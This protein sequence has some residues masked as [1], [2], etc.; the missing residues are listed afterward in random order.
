M[1]KFSDKYINNF[2]ILNNAIVG[3]EWEFY[4]DKPYYKLLEYLNRELNPVKV[5]GY[6][7][8]HSSGDVHE[9]RW[10]IE[11]DLSLGSE[12]IE[13]ISGPLPYVNAKIYL[14]KVLK[15][16]QGADFSTSDK[17]S[18]HINIS[19]DKEK[20]NKTLDKLNVLKLILNMDENFVYKYFPERENN[21]YA[22]SIKK[23]IPFKNFDFSTDAMNI[24][25]NSLELPDTKY[26]GVNFKNIYDTRI[27]YRYI[28]GE[29]Y[30]NNSSEILELMDYFIL[31]TYNCINEPLTEED[32]DLLLQYLTDNINQFKNFQRYENF[33]S[34]F[35]SIRLQ[36]DKNNQVVIV[37]T[38]YEQF[39]EQLYDIVTNTY[40]LNDCII[41]YNN[42]NQK[43]EIVDATFKTI[44]DIKNIDLIDC[45]INEGSFYNCN[46]VN[47][48]MKNV[49][50]NNCKVIYTD[51]FNSKVE[52]CKIDEGS[53]IY[54]CYLSNCYLD[55]TMKAGVFRSGKLGKNAN[56][57]NDVKII[58]ANNYFNRDSIIANGEKVD[59]SE[60]EQSDK[61]NK[62]N[63]KNQKF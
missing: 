8:Y 27:E 55:G 32:D 60:V 4:S 16:L 52:N 38:Y 2:N 49:N 51:V 20:T 34:D 37:K 46:V 11:A 24:L 29:G 42:D 1:D 9:S 26:Y 5:Y 3:F 31:L 35:P 19:F 21:F 13:L 39:Y 47:S 22:K 6:R 58:T 18:I 59:K 23:I 41:N 30:E 44:F 48:E 25:T 14:L 40:N 7:I 57:D 62:T 15:I 17:C 43:L 50:I 12:G 28:G 36:V 33:I 10:K 54:N 45:V 61:K 63:D 53:T 56:L